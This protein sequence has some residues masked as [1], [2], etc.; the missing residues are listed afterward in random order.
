MMEMTRRGLLAGT[1]AGAM[2]PRKP[3]AAT[4][5][6]LEHLKQ[7][8]PPVAPPGLS[9]MDAEGHAHTLKEYIGKG[10]VLNLWATWCAPCIAEMPSLDQLAGAITGR[11]VVVLPLSSD[12]GGAATV[13]KFY[14]QHAITRL[15]VLL[16]PAGNATRALGVSGIPVTFIIDRK[17]MERARAEGNENWNSDAA[18]QRVLQLCGV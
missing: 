18:V 12:H 11:G 16:D 4:P 5:G 15:P 17:G 10:V 9:F 14:Q 1:L 8:D 6:T 2:M 3:R 7:I 13:Q